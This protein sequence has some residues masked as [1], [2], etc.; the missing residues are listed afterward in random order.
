MNLTGTA[1][2]VAIVALLVGWMARESQ[3][4]PPAELEDVRWED[5]NE[6]RCSRADPTCRFYGR[7]GTRVSVWYRMQ[8]IDELLAFVRAHVSE[9]RWNRWRGELEKFQQGRRGITGERTP[10]RRRGGTSKV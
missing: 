4:A 3:K 5:L 7:D 8:G 10:A 2:T 9:S 6:V 1:V